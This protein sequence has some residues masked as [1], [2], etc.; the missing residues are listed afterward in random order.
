MAAIKNPMIPIVSETALA[1]PTRQKIV[2]MKKYFL[3]SNPTNPLSSD[4]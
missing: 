4:L 2:G 1:I 3:A